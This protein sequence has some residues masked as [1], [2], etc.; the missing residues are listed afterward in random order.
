MDKYVRQQARRAYVATM[1]Q[2]EAAFDL[3]LA[4]QSASNPD[5]K[6]VK[7]LNKCLQWQLKNKM[8]GL[9]FVPVDASTAKLFVF[10]NASFANNRDMS[11][12]LGFL[13][14]MA[15]EVES[16]SN[17]ATRMTGNIV[18]WGFTKCKRVTRSV[19]ASEL[20]A[21]TLGFDHT[22]I[23]KTTINK[24]FVHAQERTIPIVLCTDSHSLYKC[25]VK[26]GTTNEKRLM[27]NIMALRQA[28]KAR[29]IAEVRWINGATN[30]ANAMTKLVADNAL[31]VLIDTNTLSIRPHGWVERPGN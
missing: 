18:H 17:E 30:L 25:F 10:V 28:Y 15:N 16:E 19:L 5:K 1:S 21:M 29:E 4:A 31:K 8:H 27:I 14:A 7:L 22:S 6:D 12:Q 24:I 2:P 26:L 13:I 3:L 20:Y 9:T 11:S 23:L